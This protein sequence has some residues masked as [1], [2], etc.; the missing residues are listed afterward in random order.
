M[1]ELH[2]IMVNKLKT[3][4]FLEGYR[5]LLKLVQSLIPTIFQ[6]AKRIEDGIK[7]QL[8]LKKE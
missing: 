2:E 5:V 7:N 6:N 3:F 8:G 4:F 1:S